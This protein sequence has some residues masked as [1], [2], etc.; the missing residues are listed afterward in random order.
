MVILTEAQGDLGSAVVDYALSMAF[1]SGKRRERLPDEDGVLTRIGVE[2]LA[3]G[4]L[5]SS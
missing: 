3:Y 5:S 4:G 2:R 1:D